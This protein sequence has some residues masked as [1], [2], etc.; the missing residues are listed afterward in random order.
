[1]GLHSKMRHKTICIA[2]FLV[3]TL[4]ITTSCENHADG[5]ERQM[6]LALDSFAVSYYNW[7]YH[8]ALR[9]CTSESEPWLKFAAS[10]VT[11]EDIELLHQEAMATYE[12]QSID[13]ADD[14]TAYANITVFNFLQPDSI[15]RQPHHIDKADFWLRM[16]LPAAEGK[17]KVDLTQLPR[18]EKNKR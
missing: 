11:Q 7:Q 4:L 9:F 8:R 14:T 15:G 17:W 18:S 10:Q 5:S 16:T 2:S 3:G 6:M 13:Y 1:M 12:V